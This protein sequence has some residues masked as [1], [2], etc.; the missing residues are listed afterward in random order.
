MKSEYSR[1]VTSIVLARPQRSPSTPKNKPPHGPADEEEAGGV[2]AV[3]LDDDVSVGDVL[4]GA[5]IAHRRRAGEDEELLV[6]AVEQ[7]AEGRDDEHEPVV[8]VHVLPPRQVR[9]RRVGGEVGFVER[10]G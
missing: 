6:E 4:A 3:L 2:D 8:P 7:P 5:A 1:I 9:V 10:D